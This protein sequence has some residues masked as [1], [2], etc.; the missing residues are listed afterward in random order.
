MWAIKGLIVLGPN[1][2]IKKGSVHLISILSVEITT[3]VNVYYYLY[4]KTMMSIKR[5]KL[6]REIVKKL[7]KP[8]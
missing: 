1:F 6:I 4:S 7:Y 2:Y 8:I 3:V 5:H